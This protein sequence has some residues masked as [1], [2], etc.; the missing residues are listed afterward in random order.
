MDEHNQ[1]SR[2][3]R[4]I[5]D[6]VYARGVASASRV[7]EDMPDPLSRAT[8]RTMLRIL[9]EKG[10]LKHHKQGR[11][12]IYQPTRPR[13]RVGQSALRRVLNTFFDGSLEQVAMRKASAA[14]RQLVWLLA[15]ASLLVLPVL[16]VALPAW[17]VL[18]GWARVEARLAPGPAEGIGPDKTKEPAGEMISHEPAFDPALEPPVDPAKETAA[19]EIEPAIGA[20]APVPPPKEPLL[21]AALP[22]A[23]AVWAL[24]TLVCLAPLLLGRLSLWRLRRGCRPL[25][26]G[27]WQA[28]LNDARL[29]LGLTR[30]VALL[31]SHRRTMPMIWGIL[32]PKLLL[33][34]EADHWPAERRWVV[35]LHELGHAKRWD[36]LAKLIAHLACA[37][38]WFN[39]LAWLAFKRLQGEAERACD[40][41][42]LA[43][44]SRPHDY[45]EHILHIA[46]GLEAGMLAAH[47]GIGMARKSKLEG[48]LLAILDGRRSRR[49][50]TR[51]GVLLAVLLVAALVVPVAIM[52][53]TAGDEPPPGTQAGERSDATGPAKTVVLWL[54]DKDGEPVEGALVTVSYA[55]ADRILR[56]ASRIKTGPDG[57]VECEVPAQTAQVGVVKD[58]FREIG[59][60]LLPANGQDQ[61]ICLKRSLTVQGVVKDAV[62]GKTIDKFLL[63]PGYGWNTGRPQAVSWMRDEAKSL[64]AGKFTWSPKWDYQLARLRVEAENHVP[65]ESRPLIDDEGELRL[66]FALQPSKDVVGRLLDGG[67]KPV[68]GAEVFVATANRLVSIADGKSVADTVSMKTVED[69][70]FWV[71]P[72][73]QRFSVYVFDERGFAM[74][75]QEQLGASPE[76][77]LQPWAEITGRVVLA[78]K[79]QAGAT[80][81]LTGQKITSAGEAHYTAEARAGEDG[82]FEFACVPPGVVTVGRQ[83]RLEKGYT[84]MF[85]LDHPEVLT[86]QPGQKASVNI[87]GT[88]NPVTG[89]LLTPEGNPLQP[90]PYFIY[91]RIEWKGK[92]PEPPKLFEGITA[93]SREQAQALYDQWSKSRAGQEYYARQL[94][95]HRTYVVDIAADGS[96]RAED[97]PAG[98][99]TL[100]VNVDQVR[101]EPPFGEGRPL[102]VLRREFAMGDKP[103]NLGDLKLEPAPP[104][105]RPAPAKPAPGPL[106][107]REVAEVFLGAATAGDDEEAVRLADPNSALPR[108]L[109][110]FRQIPGVEKLKVVKV[111]ADAAVALAAT[112]ETQDDRDRRGVLLL[113]LIKLVADWRVTDIDFRAPDKAKAEYDQFLE[114]HPRALEVPAT[115]PAVQES[116]APEAAQAFLEALAKGQDETALGLTSPGRVKPEGLAKIREHYDLSQARI[117]QAFVSRQDACAVTSFF[118]PKKGDRPMAM[119]IGLR[120]HGDRWLVRDIDALPHEKAVGAYVE[121]FKAAFL[122]AAPAATTL[123]ASPQATQPASPQTQ[124]AGAKATLPGGIVVELLGVRPPHTDDKMPWYAPDGSGEV[125]MPYRQAGLR[126]SPPV[127]NYTVAFKVT[128]LPADAQNTKMGAQTFLVPAVSAAP[129]GRDGAVP[130]YEGTGPSR[131]LY[132]L[133]TTRCSEASLDV[134]FFLP[135]PKWHLAGELSPKQINGTLIV[136]GFQGVQPAKL[137]LDEVEQDQGKTVVTVRQS[138]VA[139]DD[140]ARVRTCNYDVMC[141]AVDDGGAA[142]A[143]RGYEYVSYLS[144]QKVRRKFDLPVKD[145]ARLRFHVRPYYSVRFANVSLKPGQKTDVRAMVERTPTRRAGPVARVGRPEPPPP[146]PGIVVP[147]KSAEVEAKLTHGGSLRLLAL[148]RADDQQDRW[149]APDG[150]PVTGS[151]DWRR[152]RRAW[153]S[154]GL[155]AVLE[156]VHPGASPPKAAIGP[157]G[158]EWVIPH[159]FA[160]GIQTPRPGKTPSLT[161]GF[162]AGPWKTVARLKEG[163]K[164]KIGELECA[165]E[166]VKA[167]GRKD[168][169]FPLFKGTI[170][171]SYWFTILPEKDVAL[172]AVDK[173]GK[174]HAV[175][176]TWSPALELSPRG[177]VWRLPGQTVMID[178]GDLD[179]FLLK[180]RPRAWATFTGFA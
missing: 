20:A 153:A 76:L 167:G 144:P 178:I 140:Q 129:F 16:S 166:D 123:P 30:P 107:A 17:Q 91:A 122:D 103:V 86:L 115:P 149:W 135:V 1:L 128:G 95:S 100:W 116:P 14:A 131:T 6:I 83:V 94:A 56:Q 2:R 19:H 37:V 10:H 136:D 54:V 41:L 93:T 173:A 13:R 142:H 67:G 96:L 38:Y 80:V 119:G 27:T 77:L 60:R 8:V 29:K 150:S 52:K 110:E 32:R 4:Q 106:T 48:R 137:T 143:S 160:R 127:A 42:V 28:L 11:E 124:P 24:G 158:D 118:P 46:S 55:G 125:K 102:W 87:G 71:R 113:R 111:H 98:D 141:V 44:G 7:L 130:W 134:R 172:L 145:V 53:A 109:K 73:G 104:R 121:S 69:G 63:V 12:F 33:P 50:L 85:C 174:E 9:E 36:C 162:S 117:V 156:A 180:T 35:L 159:I 90:E 59:H 161:V 97:I 70:R 157:A 148:G 18:P 57:R 51:I 89:R 58:G 45:A 147:A 78:G 133:H 31:Q 43:A 105:A 108:Q 81:T 155:I 154:A 169:R 25:D 65:A 120:K 114:D 168:P 5:M 68:A 3:E 165:L 92:T 66:E 82:K 139:G 152:Y 23:A 72:Q 47:A 26:G 61:V 179:H 88:G 132:L 34:A 164:A 79:P 170:T 39:P 177:T 99:Y 138:G 126:Q 176:C 40:D 49:S 151:P 175:G 146:P 112:T 101:Q 163:E 21:A 15:M 64:A 74:A 75:T 84:A 22:W 171:V 62:T